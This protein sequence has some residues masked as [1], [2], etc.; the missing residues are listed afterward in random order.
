MKFIGIDPG[1]SN[2]GMASI[3]TCNQLGI[4]SHKTWLFAHMTER[5]ITTAIRDAT[6]T[7]DQETVVV[8]VEKQGTRPTDARTNIATLH[9]HLGIVRGCLF[10]ICISF[11]DVAPA[12]WQKTFHLLFP[13]GTSHVV[14]KNKHKAKAQQLFPQEKVTHGN[15]DA[16]L[17]AEYGRRMY[18]KDG[19]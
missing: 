3:R 18:L 15:A 10:T 13:K 11:E 1:K 16:L 7:S 14:K 6:S 8:L 12:M 5:D 9:H 4:L 19:R 2:G 17:I